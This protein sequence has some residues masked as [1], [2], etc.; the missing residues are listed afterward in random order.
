MINFDV[1][2][3]INGS[4]DKKIR[5]ELRKMLFNSTARPLRKT[6]VRANNIEVDNK[7]DTGDEEFQKIAQGYEEKK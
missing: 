4:N 2:Q 5:G 7:E 3:A 6:I 1:V